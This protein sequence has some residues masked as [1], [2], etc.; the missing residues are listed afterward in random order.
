M[1][2]GWINLDNN[3]A[4]LVYKH[5]YKTIEVNNATDIIIN[6]LLISGIHFVV[7]RQYKLNE[8]Y[9]LE[10]KIN[11][12][13]ILSDMITEFYLYG[14]AIFK[15]YND[16]IIGPLYKVVSLRDCL[17][18][19]KLNSKTGK[20]TYE[21]YDIISSKK[22]SNYFVVEYFKNKPNNDGTFN[23]PIVNL[24]PYYIKYI[25]F[26]QLFDAT[27]KRRCVPLMTI[28]KDCDRQTAQTPDAKEH[29]NSDQRTGAV[30]SLFI[31][32]KIIPS[33]PW[34]RAK[35]H[36]NERIHL[37]I[38]Q[39]IE[40]LENH[41]IRTRITNSTAYPRLME[42]PKGVKVSHIIKP[43]FIANMEH[44]YRKWLENVCISLKVPIE[45]LTSISTMTRWKPDS[46]LTFSRFNTHIFTLA[47][48]VMQILN[49]LLIITYIKENGE[50][51]EIVHKF[52][53]PRDC[54][55]AE[56]SLYESISCTDPLNGLFSF[57]EKFDADW[58]P[59]DSIIKCY[60]GCVL[61]ITRKKHITE[62]PKHLEILTLF[63]R[64]PKNSLS[65]LIATDLLQS[66]YNSK[67]Y[68]EIAMTS[69]DETAEE[70]LVVRPNKKVRIE[71]GTP[72]NDVDQNIADPMYFLQE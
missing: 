9:N 15:Q 68:R 5:V 43:E 69:V 18:R 31:D 40:E 62:T 27:I 23:S 53:Q 42:F 24:W 33:D 7:D 4:K 65:S 25:H 70:D 12:E 41:P 2:S 21:V 1:D 57:H 35:H 3:F 51:Q 60:L 36:D 30:D 49:K 66:L 8:N 59:A 52:L 72:L 56:V 32:E 14:L 10:L 64:L 50:P 28:S 19:F 39:T 47:T 55:S 58:F 34:S 26:Q 13:E 54:D 44:T 17:V 61:D 6:Q 67:S 11:Y 29:K 63:Q 48:Y 20:R 16:E 37:E 22:L 45:Y 46:A 38:K 71:Q